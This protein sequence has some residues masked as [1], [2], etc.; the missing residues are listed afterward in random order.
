MSDSAPTAVKEPLAS[1]QL[2]LQAQAA[3]YE[4]V[5]EWEAYAN[6]AYQLS[7]IRKE[8][9]VQVRP[10]EVGYAVDFQT[11][12]PQLT[13][14]EDLQSLEQLALRLAPL[15]KRVVVQATPTGRVVGLLNHGEL[16]QNWSQLS[17]S[18]RAA[19]LPGDEVTSTVLDFMSRQLQSPASFLLSLGHDYLY[20]S[21][22]SDFYGQ[23]LHR[24]AMGRGRRF[25]NFF[26]KLALHFT[27][28]LTVQPGPAAGLLTLVVAGMLNEQLTDM[29]AV[30]AQIAQA[31]HLDPPS[32][33]PQG[34]PAE[35]PAPHAHYQATHVLSLDTGLPVSV[36]L[37]VYVRAGQLFNKQY[38]LTIMRQ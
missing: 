23:P 6:G 8:V 31:L 1:T 37:V 29:V 26:N 2:H 28:Q 33:G 34:T 36:E 12:P 4:V 32:A 14:P 3:A 13:K 38:T 10:S 15:Y 35:V 16:L 21:L 22:L 19:S 7:T 11:S 30:Q 24:L 17:E 18:L 5:I 9:T 20:H 27:E 25:S